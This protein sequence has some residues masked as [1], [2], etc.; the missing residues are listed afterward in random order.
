MKKFCCTLPHCNRSFDTERG[1]FYHKIKDPMHNRNI[2]YASRN[3]IGNKRHF[4]IPN[5]ERPYN[6][7]KKSITGSEF[8]D[9]A[10]MS[11]MMEADDEKST[12]VDV[13]DEIVDENVDEFS[14]TDD[15]SSNRDDDDGDEE[16]EE[17]NVDG[18]EKVDEDENNI[19]ITVAILNVN[20][21]LLKKYNLEYIK[22]QHKLYSEIYG[23][24]ALESENLQ[25]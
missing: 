19:D 25:Q 3:K 1:L 15:I 12:G 2:S 4:P 22:Y 7:R 6:F 20:P 14:R 24:G 21:E 11:N 23:I 9:T 16:D 10:T 18:E 17:K 8:I 5:N 13:E